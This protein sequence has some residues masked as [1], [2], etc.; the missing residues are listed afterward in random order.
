M[1]CTLSTPRRPPGRAKDTPTVLK[2]WAVWYKGE[3]PLGPV[4]PPDE[5]DEMVRAEAAIYEAL[6]KHHRILDYLGLKVAVLK[7]AGPKPCAWAL[8]L[9]RAPGGI[10]LRN[11]L[12]AHPASPPGPRNQLALAWQFAEGLAYVH[13]RGVAWVDV[14]TRNVLLFGEWHLKICEFGLSMRYEDHPRR[15]WAAELR[16]KPPGPTPR[17]ICATTSK[18]TSSIARSTP[19]AP[20]FMSLPSGGCRTAPSTTC[21]G[22]RSSR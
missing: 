6:G 4:Q 2:G 20:P 17:P 22:R 5:A 1:S 12:Y 3:E 14:S 9:E 11:Y 16:Y 7:G 18:S 13:A 21:R 10:N 19:S 15:L 8:R